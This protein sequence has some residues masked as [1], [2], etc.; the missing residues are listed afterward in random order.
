[1]A[2]ASYIGEHLLE[3]I[4]I[5]AP[6][7]CELALRN[8]VVLSCGN[9][10]RTTLTGR[11]IGTGQSSSSSNHSRL[12][13]QPHMQPDF[14]GPSTMPGL[15]TCYAP[16]QRC[17]C[18]QALHDCARL[19]EATCQQGT[20]RYSPNP[21]GKNLNESVRPKGEIVPH[22]RSQKQPIK[23]RAPGQGRPTLSGQRK[24]YVHQANGRVCPHAAT[25]GPS[26]R[27]RT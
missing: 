4:F 15:H 9:G 22:K 23:A 20:D 19:E 26:R 25:S 1:M 3:H 10:T 16:G 2:Q 8:A 21:S 18:S 14:K 7:G 27:I 11:R 24:G 13:R 12:F 17:F 6:V 5:V